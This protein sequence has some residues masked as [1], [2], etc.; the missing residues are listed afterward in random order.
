MC[1]CVFFSH[2]TKLPRL[3]SFFSSS[4]QR[5]VCADISG[6]SRRVFQSSFC[7]REEKHIIS[8]GFNPLISSYFIYWGGSLLNYT[9]TGRGGGLLSPDNL[10][11]CICE[12]T[13]FVVCQSGG[14]HG[15][16]P[17]GWGRSPPHPPLPHS[18]APL[19]S[20]SFLVFFPPH[21][22]PRRSSSSSRLSSAPPL[23]R[24]HL[25]LVNHRPAEPPPPPPTKPPR[26]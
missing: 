23:C 10:I 18:L 7:C 26:R 19:F 8:P 2:M 21:M 20:L 3:V 1:V 24:S 15:D 14:C 22:A 11:V 4:T 13:D 9:D 16:H 6:R 25:L 17:G 12:I 5:H